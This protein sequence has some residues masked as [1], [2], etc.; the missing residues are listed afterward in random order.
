[1]AE[2]NQKI[3]L[4][5]DEARML[6]LGA[7]ILLGFEYRIFLEPTFDELP[8]MVQLL[9]LGGLGAILLT[10]M[11][12]M[13]PAA[14]QQITE[15]G[16]ATPALHEFA[17]KVMCDALLPFAMAIGID[18]YTVS[19][20]VGGNRI[21]IPFGTA[22]A[23]TALFFW[24]VLG[25]LQRRPRERIMNESNAT[26]PAKTPLHDKIDDVL[27]ECRV[28]IPGAQALLGFQLIAMFMQ[29][30]EKLPRTSQF[31]H[32]ASLLLMALSTIL[33]M[34]PAAYHRIVEHGED[35]VR[36]WRHARI[37]LLSA[38]VPLAAGLAGD[39]YVVIAKV[40]DSRPAAMA[41]ATAM[42]AFFYGFWFGFTFYKRFRSAE[43]EQKH[44][45]LIHAL[46]R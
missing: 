11:L 9:R 34:T 22:T 19:A 3:K 25:Y 29:S 39:S 46:S 37:M 12:L 44:A 28:V 6:V 13:W 23:A 38:M 27:T 1:M 41:A 33:L 2:L 21:G 16:N 43:R 4:S 30:F 17:T 36:F 10:T 40:T 42:L 15:N 31:V 45:K 32:L 7:Q 18:V 26:Q 5:L 14:Y 8:R 35:T 24:Y 20:K